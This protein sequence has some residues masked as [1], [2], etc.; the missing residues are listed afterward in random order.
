[1][2]NED[3]GKSYTLLNQE[4]ALINF[5]GIQD[6]DINAGVDYSSNTPLFSY[7]GGGQTNN[8]AWAAND[9]FSRWRMQFGLRYIFN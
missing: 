6:D 4:F 5:E 2:L 7:T 8:K 1:M 9:F 3:W